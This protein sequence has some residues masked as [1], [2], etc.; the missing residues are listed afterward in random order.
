MPDPSSYVVGLEGATQ[1]TDTGA[2]R[3]FRFQ[4]EITF[5]T[6]AE[7]ATEEADAAIDKLIAYLK[8]IGQMPE[9]PN[10]WQPKK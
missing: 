9:E 1:D 3:R 4:K 8:S 10:W 7:H 5:R 6:V 2:K